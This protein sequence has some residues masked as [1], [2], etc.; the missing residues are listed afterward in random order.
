MKAQQ[1]DLK[2]KNRVV[3][4]WIQELTEVMFT[5]S[6]KNAENLMTKYWAIENVDDDNKMT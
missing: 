2:V 3:W 5:M 4:L 1:C 6:R